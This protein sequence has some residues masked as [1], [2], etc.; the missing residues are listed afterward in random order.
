MKS[1]RRV[2]SRVYAW[3]FYEA[4]TLTFLVLFGFVGGVLSGNEHMAL[5]EIFTGA[6]RYTIVPF[7]VW[8]MYSLKVSLYNHVVSATPGNIFLRQLGL[9]PT[10]VKWTAAFLVTLEQSVPIIL[11]ALFLFSVAFRQQRYD[12]LI[13]LVA[14]LTLILTV[15][16]LGLYR[17]WHQAREGTQR[18]PSTGSSYLIIVL[19]WLFRSA[20]GLILLTKVFDIPFLYGLCKLHQFDTYDVR[21]LGMGVTITAAMNAFILHHFMRFEHHEF[22]LI[23]ALPIP[24]LRRIMRILLLIMMLL[25]PELIVLRWN[26]PSSITAWEQTE[27]VLLLATFPFAAYTALLGRS[28]TLDQFARL[29]FA[30][31]FSVVIAILFRLPLPVLLSGIFAYCLLFP[32]RYHKY[33]YSL[34]K[35]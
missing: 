25:L 10:R 23:R 24:M 26:L 6:P 9:A 5:A 14:E 31:T 4:N 8:L 21:L 32:G 13:V 22:Q 20:P 2:I 33:E 15:P 29:I 34:Q 7:G 16:T 27:L 18:I 35:S 19:R 17:L 3:S 11:Y 12:S 28:I 30:V 1:I